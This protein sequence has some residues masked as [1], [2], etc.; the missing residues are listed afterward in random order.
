MACHLQQ[1]PHCWT[2][3]GIGTDAHEGD[4]L[5]KLRVDEKV[6]VRELARRFGYLEDHGTSHLTVIDKDRNAV[7][8]TSSINTIFGSGVLSE[9]TGIVLNSQVSLV[10]FILEANLSYVYSLSMG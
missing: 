7:S 4:R 2:H 1:A 6:S 5:R 3:K 10:V 9:S 8:I